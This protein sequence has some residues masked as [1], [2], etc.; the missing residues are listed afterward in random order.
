MPTA[1]LSSLLAATL[2]FATVLVTAVPSSA[3]AVSFISATAFTDSNVIVD[4]AGNLYGT[5][6]L[7]GTSQA[8][9][10]GCGYVF[11]LSPASDGSWTQTTIFNFPSGAGGAYPATGLVIDSK[12]RLFGTTSSGGDSACNCG[13][14]F[15][16]TAS[17]SGQW[18]ETVIHTFT[19]P[20]GEIPM[21]NLTFDSHGNLF[22][23]TTIGGAY[24]YG[25]LFM[26][27]PTSSG[28]KESAVLNFTKNTTGSGASS[29]LFDSAGNL[30]AS[31][32]SAG[33]IANCGAVIQLMRAS[34]GWKENKLHIFTGKGSDG[35]YPNSL[36]FDATGHLYGV[37]GG[38][39]ADH[40]GVVFRLTNSSG[41]WKESTLY[42]FT[43]G[44]DGGQP[45]AIAFSPA[46]QL[47]GMT[48][49]GAPN[50]CTSLF[51][52]SQVFSLTSSATG[53]SVAATYPTPNGFPSNAG[54]T[55][56]NAGNLFGTVSDDHY[57]VSSDV[58]E[59]TP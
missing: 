42:S 57:E 46:G 1:K 58:F 27:S 30:Y 37:A 48:N 6:E 11:E 49:Y 50:G 5:A 55:F 53:W 45:A 54:L 56:D 34:S 15:M 26:L 14:V 19:G 23:A 33:N 18:T 41:V 36:R 16:L 9:K 59:L 2:L 21:T 22:G 28:W 7:G 24:A 52:C 25:N 4:S 39:G 20:D 32:L 35:C 17:S 31:L 40:Q 8:C 3:Q 29:L 43:G 47:Y 44:N 10:L 38:G 12:G 51:G 13:T